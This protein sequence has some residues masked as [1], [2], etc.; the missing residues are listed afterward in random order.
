PITTAWNV[1]GPGY[2]PYNRGDLGR[3][4]FLFYT[5]AY[6]EYNFKLGSKYNLQLSVNLSNVFN[7]ETATFISGNV[8]RTNITPGDDVLVKGNWTPNPAAKKDGYYLKASSFFAPMQARF[9]VKFS[10]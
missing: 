2:Y 1:D 4:P 6:A 7:V 10:F 8:Y 3:T 5:D 9:G